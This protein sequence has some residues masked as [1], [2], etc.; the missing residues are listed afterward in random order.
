M[1]PMTLYSLPHPFNYSWPA[2]MSM[3][4]SWTCQLP[5]ELL[6]FHRY[7]I[8]NSQAKPT[9]IILKS[10][11]ML[12]FSSLE[13]W[14]SLLHSNSWVTKSQPTLEIPYLKIC[15]FLKPSEV[16]DSGAIFSKRMYTWW[17]SFPGLSPS[18]YLLFHSTT[19]PGMTVFFLLGFQECISL[20]CRFST[21][22][23]TLPNVWVSS[24]SGFLDSFW[25]RTNL[26]GA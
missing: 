23:N 12:M 19:S 2:D 18:F 4:P 13:F 5:T 24:Q 17:L 10:N 22:P 26:S 9:L 21:V 3:N 6:A 8:E 15:Y 1:R 11:Q 16:L 25:F 7:T 20:Y 14:S